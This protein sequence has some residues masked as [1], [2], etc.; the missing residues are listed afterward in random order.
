M[1]K[2][3]THDEIVRVIGRTKDS[4]K[5]YHSDQS[6]LNKKCFLENLNMLKDIVSHYTS[7]VDPSAAE[8]EFI[9]NNQIIISL[10][11]GFHHMLDLAQK[12]FAL[13]NLSW[14]VD[15]KHFLFPSSFVIFFLS[16]LL[17]IMIV[18]IYYSV[19]NVHGES[20]Q[21]IWNQRV[22]LQTFRLER[23]RT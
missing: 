21:A 23:C 20:I 5:N 9:A 7:T 13:L 15:S 6:V 16:H 18:W 12:Q 17:I 3:L 1:I 19:R 11:S 8:N 4:L 10:S 14:K 2:D 22:G